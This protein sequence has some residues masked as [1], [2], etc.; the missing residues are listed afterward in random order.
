MYFTTEFMERETSM[1]LRFKNAQSF[2]KR[3][4]MTLL[5]TSW[6][7]QGHTRDFL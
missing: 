3:L 1:L 7:E 5:K 4:F 2:V 6:A